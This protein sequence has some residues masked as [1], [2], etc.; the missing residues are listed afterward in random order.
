VAV[1]HPS[2]LDHAFKPRGGG[3]VCYMSQSA[4]STIMLPVMLL[5]AGRPAS[6]NNG[7]HGFPST[8]FSRST[9]HLE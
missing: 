6:G 8:R 1:S 4:I 3:G 9:P 2:T 7:R 5:T